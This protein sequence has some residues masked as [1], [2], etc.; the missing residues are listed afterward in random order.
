MDIKN[1]RYLLYSSL[2]LLSLLNG[3]F[4]TVY[5][6]SILN[7]EIIDKCLPAADFEGCVRVL[8]KT[9]QNK[10]KQNKNKVNM[11]RNKD[12][13]GR[14]KIPGWR[15]IENYARNEVFYI[16]ERGIAKVQVRG[17]YGRYISY[18]YIKRYY[19]EPVPAIPGRYGEWVPGET[20]CIKEDNEER[21]STKPATRP[22]YPGRAA[23]PGYVDQVSTFVV[24]DCFERT[25]KWS[26]GDLRWR[27]IRGTQASNIANNYCSK[28]KELPESSITKYK[29]G[30]PTDDDFRALS[31]LQSKINRFKSY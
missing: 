24:I 26:T 10:N 25:G 3:A 31:E 20:V 14:E 5:S 30:S 8:K 16:N 1:M 28:I 21:C 7:N 22:W 29:K 18:D 11:K 12:I 4:N 15:I 23:V 9:N 19:V 13:L 27:N 2:I 17:I 6:K